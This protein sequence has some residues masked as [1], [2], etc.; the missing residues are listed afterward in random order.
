MKAKENTYLQDGIYTKQ[1]NL[2][3]GHKVLQHRHKYSHTSILAVGSVELVTNG[4]SKIVKAP[5]V[6]HLKANDLHYLVALEDSMWFCIH[7]T[8]ETEVSKV[9]KKLIK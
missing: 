8:D 5:E 7:H 3:K 6:L 2:P 4:I 9:C 1:F